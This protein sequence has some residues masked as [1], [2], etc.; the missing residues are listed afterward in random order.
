M[1]IPICYWQKV[2]YKKKFNNKKRK[3]KQNGQ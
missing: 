3:I 2:K 1:Q